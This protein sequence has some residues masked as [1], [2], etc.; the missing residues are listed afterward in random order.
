MTATPC[1]RPSSATASTNSLAPQ[2]DYYDLGS[3]DSPINNLQTLELETGGCAVR[4]EGTLPLSFFELF[5]T[6]GLVFS[7]VEGSLGGPEVFDES[8]NDLVYSVGAGFGIVERL[9]LR[10]EYEI[11]D[12][13]SFDDSEAIW[14][15]AAWRL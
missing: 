4:V 15:T 13:E 7:D 9:V 5:A 10:L 6:A 3:W 2:F 11:I 14:F 12:I 8:D 1:T